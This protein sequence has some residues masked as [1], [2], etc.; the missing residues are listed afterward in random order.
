M[1]GK[2]EICELITLV[3]F[4][5]SFGFEHFCMR[6]EGPVMR[7]VPLQGE[8]FLGDIFSLAPDFDRKERYA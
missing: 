4:L 8:N 1:D 5:N 2:S 6:D 3:D 7:L